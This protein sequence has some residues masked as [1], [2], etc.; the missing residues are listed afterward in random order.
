[1]KRNPSKGKFLSYYYDA[2]NND[3]L[4]HSFLY[5]SKPLFYSSVAGTVNNLGLKWCTF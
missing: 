5:F 4:E 1:M 2:D 3:M